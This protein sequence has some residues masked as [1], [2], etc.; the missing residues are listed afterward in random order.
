M[1][2]VSF[3]SI[4][5]NSRFYEGVIVLFMFASAHLA[6][7][8]V[9]QRSAALTNGKSIWLGTPVCLIYAPF[10]TGLLLTRSP[11]FET[12]RYSTTTRKKQK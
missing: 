9:H 4:H 10:H 2:E 11:F 3:S 1:Y 6:Y 5:I 12:N 8:R 7:R